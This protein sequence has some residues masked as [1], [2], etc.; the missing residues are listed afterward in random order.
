MKV[1]DV[2]VGDK[3]VLKDA[4]PF[5][6]SGGKLAPGDVFLDIVVANGKLKID[7]KSIKGGVENGRL[8]I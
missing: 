3:V 2:K 6:L 1:F 4:D 7:G 5:L 8:M